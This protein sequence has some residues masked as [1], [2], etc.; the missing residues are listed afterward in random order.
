MGSIHYDISSTS[1]GG[2]PV[3]ITDVGHRRYKRGSRARSHTLKNLRSEDHNDD[4]DGDT[5]AVKFAMLPNR[6]RIT[7]S[8][9]LR[10]E[11]GLEPEQSSKV[12]N[13]QDMIHYGMLYKTSRGKITSNPVRGQHE[14]K[15]YRRFQLTERSLEYSQ[16]I[17][18]VCSRIKQL[19][20]KYIAIA[21]T[22]D[23]AL[24]N[25]YMY[26]RRYIAIAIQ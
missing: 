2:A 20:H 8:A 19:Q 12:K 14:H 9:S 23:I 26:V 17:Q 15:Q 24:Y 22:I 25:S 21:T 3:A 7:R 11:P 10:L 13:N 18:R 4:K 16:L 6:S 5:D 1:S